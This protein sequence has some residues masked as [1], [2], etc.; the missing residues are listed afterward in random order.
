MRRLIC[1]EC[2]KEKLKQVGVKMNI[3]IGYCSIGRCSICRKKCVHLFA[4]SEKAE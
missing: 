4:Y 3:G 1:E 2:K